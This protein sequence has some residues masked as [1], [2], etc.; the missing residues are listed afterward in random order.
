MERTIQKQYKDIHEHKNKKK[1]N[2]NKIK[3]EVIIRLSNIE[4]YINQYKNTLKP[5]RKTI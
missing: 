5:I 1:Q 4:N 3:N 2:K